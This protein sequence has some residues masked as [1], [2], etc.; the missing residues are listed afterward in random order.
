M[1]PATAKARPRNDSRP[2]EQVKGLPYF[3][4]I[5]RVRSTSGVAPGVG[6]HFDSPEFRAAV[7]PS[8]HGLFAKDDNDNEIE[9]IAKV[10]QGTFSQDGGTVLAAPSTRAR[11]ARRD[12]PHGERHTAPRV[13]RTI[14]PCRKT[15]V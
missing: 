14:V 8:I 5:N 11:A 15:Y 7:M 10:A 9:K 4:T 13:T 12:Q 3:S 1:S 6:L 2:K